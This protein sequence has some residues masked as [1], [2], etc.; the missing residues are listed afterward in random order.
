MIEQRLLSIDEVFVYRIP[1]MRSA[2]GHRAE[3]WN[4]A[5]P[6][7][8]CSLVVTRR[9]D[10]LRIDIMAERPKPRAPSGATET[11]LFARSQ[12]SVVPSDPGRGIEHWI[13]P[14]VDSSRY[15]ALR[16]RNA[17]TGREAFVG[18]GFRERVDATNFR[19]GVEDY[20]SSLRREEKAAALHEKFERSLSVGERRDAVAREGGGGD[21]A[22]EVV[23]EKLPPPKSSLCLKEGEK[24]RIHINTGKG[25]A[26]APPRKQHSPNVK[27]GTAG[28]KGLKKPPPP[29]GATPAPEISGEKQSSTTGD[30]D[31]GTTDDAVDW[32]DFEG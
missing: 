30:G 19:M 14:A 22:D 7:A 13:V 21:V 27:K 3:D 28:L 29:P 20:V 25:G 15:F 24:I 26:N 23:E 17:G 8:T 5:K 31:D 4:L 18:V 11:Y 2:D 6:L 10:D 12:M 9:D 16:I 1:P 32:G